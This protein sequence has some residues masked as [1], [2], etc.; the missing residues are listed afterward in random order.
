MKRYSK[1][2]FLIAFCTITATLSLISHAI[3]GTTEPAAAEEEHVAT[4]QEKQNTTTPTPEATKAAKSIN[5]HTHTYNPAHLTEAEKDSLTEALLTEMGVADMDSAHLFLPEIHSHQTHVHS[6]SKSFPDSNP[7]QLKA[8]MAIG[9]KPV[10]TREEAQE[11]VNNNQLV[12]ITNSP[13]YHID[14]L[15][16]SIPYLV[17]QAQDLL[18][19]ICINFIDSLKSKDIPPH[20]PIVTSVLRTSKDIKKLQQGNVNS[21]T[22]SCHCY[23]TTVDITY[24]RFLPITGNHKHSKTHILRYDITMKKILAE[25]LLDLRMQGRCYVKHEIKQACFHLTARPV[26]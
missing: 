18:N 21:T 20:L 17:P 15:T 7:V 10:R 9:I 6:Y 5:T 2:R 3:I 26:H 23:G 4:L 14:P 25:V 16:H 13:Y 24:N 12:N 11:Y 19:T 1:K 22:N 8:A